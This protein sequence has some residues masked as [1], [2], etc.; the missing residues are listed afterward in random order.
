MF[1]EHSAIWINVQREE[2]KKG[3]AHG[4]QIAGANVFKLLK[5]LKITGAVA[6]SVKDPF[7]NINGWKRT[8]R[9]N[10][11]VYTNGLTSRNLLLLV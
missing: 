9:K 8:D 5:S 3:I 10:L 1:T 2:L 6:A 7:G 4:V 11:L